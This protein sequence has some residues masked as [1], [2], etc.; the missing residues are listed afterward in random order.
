MTKEFEKFIK[1]IKELDYYDKEILIS[2]SSVDGRLTENCQLT[3]LRTEV[4]DKRIILVG[5]DSE[6]ITIAK[7]F[8]LM[9]GNGK[10]F[11]F[12]SE[13]IVMVVEILS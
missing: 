3:L 7:D 13:H 6:I 8:E 5:D 12:K 10:T 2:I 9:E 4:S 1:T 11:I